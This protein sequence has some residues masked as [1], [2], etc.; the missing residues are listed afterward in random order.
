MKKYRSRF[1]QIP[2]EI[3]TEITKNSNTIA[4]II[5]KCEMISSGA[6]YK[7]LKKRLEMENIDYSHIKLG[8]GSN[9]GR[10]FIRDKIP[11]DQILVE[12]SNYNRH[13]LKKRLISELGWSNTCFICKNNGTW[14]GKKLTIQL[15]HINGDSKDN[16]IENLRFLCP[17]CHSQTE[18]FAGKQSRL[19]NKCKICSGRV[20][21]SKSKHCIECYKKHIAP[22]IGLNSRKIDRPSK[23]ILIQDVNILGFKGTGRKYNVSDN[24]IRKW[25][26]N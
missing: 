9:K 21:S 14:L 26:K 11:L 23:D 7:I 13:N 17:N 19:K 16:R 2:K 25:L 12:N 6:S 8:L 4:E 5:K 10:T 20:T 24:T 3:L 15:D 22:E 1:W 18:T